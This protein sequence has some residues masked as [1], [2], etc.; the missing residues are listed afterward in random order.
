MFCDMKP[1]AAAVLLF[2]SASSLLAE[3]VTLKQPAL[4]KSGRNAVSLKPG[5]VV[6]LISRD[7]KE[8]T[9]KYKDLTGK[10]P[11]DR[12]EEP[13]VSAPAAK[14]VAPAAKAPAPVAKTNKAKEKPPATKPTL[15]ETPQTG[16]GKA[17]KKAKD[18]AAAHDRN[19]LKPNDEV[20]KEP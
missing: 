5:A 4:L 16:Y 19:V 20:L 8:I 18:T 1:H 7:G 13:K 17:V 10:I 3:V 11:A 14:A 15:S 12:L 9:V 6:E 2:L